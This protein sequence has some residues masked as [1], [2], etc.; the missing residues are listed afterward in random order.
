MDARVVNSLHL[1]PRSQQELSATFDR[2]MAKWE[3]KV[4]RAQEGHTTR[5]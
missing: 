2:F 1:S 3:K 4:E 5:S